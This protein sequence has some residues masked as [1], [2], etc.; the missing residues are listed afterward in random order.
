MRLRGAVRGAFLPPAP[1]PTYHPSATVCPAGIKKECSVV[2]QA[3]SVMPSCHGTA[4]TAR[5]AGP[6]ALMG[7]MRL[8]CAQR[9]PMEGRLVPHLLHDSG[10]LVNADANGHELLSPRLL[11]WRRLVLLFRTKVSVFPS[12]LNNLERV[13]LL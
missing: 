10:L 11:G 1:S 2:T 7:S 12:M 13:S 5:H 6:H 3:L 9:A 4:F 8:T